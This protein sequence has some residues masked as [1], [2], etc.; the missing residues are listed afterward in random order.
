MAYL[1][2]E[3]VKQAQSWIGSKE[4]DGSHKKIIDL[5]NAH[6]PLARSYKV[7][8]N[9][10]W[11]ATFV[12]ACAIKCGYTAIIPT[13]CSCQSM[14]DLFKKKGIWMENDTYVPS[15]G[16]IIFY[17]WDD[18][19]RGDNTGW[20]DHVGIVERVVGTTITVIEGNYSNSVKRRNIQV[21]ARYIRGYGVPK[22]SAE[23]KPAATNS[24]VKTVSATKGAESKDESLA[25]QYTTTANLNMR[26]GAGKSDGNKI[27]V[28][29]P[30]GTKVRCY[31]Y[32]TVEAGVKWLYVRAT[33]KGVVYTGFC[34]SKFLKR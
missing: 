27:L 31:G 11:C 22:Y 21:N 15:A 23:P 9:D 10:H 2:S 4:S 25:G 7:K 14:I 8:Y 19:G 34:S 1:R 16:D 30:K 33:H 29:L 26:D 17:D 20:S 32:Y 12:S 5:Y 3:I 28:I 6:S 24:S 18:S 13:E